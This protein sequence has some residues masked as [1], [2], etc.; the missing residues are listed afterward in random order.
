MVDKVPTVANAKRQNQVG[1]L[2]DE[3]MIRL[4]RALLV[5]LGLA[6]RSSEQP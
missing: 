4:N 6:G 2:S 1:K 3:D 5:F